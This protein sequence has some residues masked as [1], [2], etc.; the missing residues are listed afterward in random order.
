MAIFHVVRGSG[1]DVSGRP[2]EGGSLEP[3]QPPAS[4]RGL[5][6]AW[7]GLLSLADGQVKIV[8]AQWGVFLPL[9]RPVNCFSHL[10]VRRL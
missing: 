2:E 1:S 3:W 8:C 4:W 5:K 7:R 10:P 9:L 6:S